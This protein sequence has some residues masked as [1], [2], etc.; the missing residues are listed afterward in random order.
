MS[1][2]ATRSDS[3]IPPESEP[4]Y[5]YP[6]SST[7]LTEKEH[8]LYS[9]IETAEQLQRDC[10]K[11]FTIDEA[12]SKFP[13]SKARE[14]DLLR[15]K[16]YKNNAGATRTGFDLHHEAITNRVLSNQIKAFGFQRP[17]LD[18]ITSLTREV[19]DLYQKKL[20][21]PARISMN[22][23]RQAWEN[24]L[25]KGTERTPL[26]ELADRYREFDPSWQQDSLSALED[27]SFDNDFEEFKTESDDELS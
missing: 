23:A 2:A 22:E 14:L 15:K 10:K 13:H 11:G 8:S 19:T 7:I 1:V 9:L 27:Q 4:P 6:G 26:P 16:E 20:D 25:P 24:Y 18:A 17:Q 3:P 12:L 5:T 21:L